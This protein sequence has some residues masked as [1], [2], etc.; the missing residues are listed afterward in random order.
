M[1]YWRIFLV[2]TAT[3]IVMLE[4]FPDVF[5]FRGPLGIFHKG[6]YTTGSDIG[7]SDVGYVMTG[8]VFSPNSNF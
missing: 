4:V 2:P 5:D 8:K 6:V 3:P 7:F 1:A